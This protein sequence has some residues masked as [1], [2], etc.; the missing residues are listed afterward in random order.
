M[1]QL[2]GTEQCTARQ[3]A[4]DI[5]ELPVTSKSNR[6]VLAV[7]EYFARFV[8][9]CEVPDQTARSVAQCLFHDYGIPET[10]QGD[11]E[12]QFQSEIVQRPCQLLGITKTRTAPCNHN[13]RKD[14][15]DVAAQT[16][17]TS[18]MGLLDEDTTIPS[19][20]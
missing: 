17:A 4:T 12:R 7:E 9:L 13:Q 20:L 5:V 18:L 16:S 15:A 11:Q 19:T 1:P 10:L 6:Y 14:V 2:G 3:G 8:R